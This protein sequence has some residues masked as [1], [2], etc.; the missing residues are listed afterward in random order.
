[1]HSLIFGTFLGSSLDTERPPKD[2]LIYGA[3]VALESFYRG[4]LRYGTFDEYHFFF[5]ASVVAQ[6]FK[7]NLQALGIYT[8]K[9]KLI[10][11]DRL[12]A[13][14]QKNKYTIFLADQISGLSEV[15]YLR[16]RY[17]K[18]LFP[19]CALTHSISYPEMLKEQFFENLLSDVYPF[20]S[21]ICTSTA[22]LKAIKKLYWLASN[23]AK[24]RLGLDLEYK[25][26]FKHLP[27]GINIGDYKKT[28]KS[29][30]RRLLGLPQDK[31]IILYFGRFS[32]YDKADLEP[33]LIA[34]KKVLEKRSDIL[35]LLAGRDAQGRYGIKVKK[36]AQDMGLSSKVRFFLNPS[37][38]NKYLL[39]SASDIFTSP[40]DSIQESFGLT[41][42]EAMA[43]GLATVVSDWDGYK[44]IVI[45]KK[46][47]FLVPTFWAD[48]DNE[49]AY[50][51]R[52][53]T[54]AQSHFYLSQSVCIDIEKMA[55][56]LLK[57]IKDKNLCLSLG[58]NSRQRVLENYD[59]KV[60]V[61]KYEKL[62]KEMSNLSKN[63]TL[64]SRKNKFL[65]PDYIKC[66]GHYP[67]RMLDERAKITI[68]KNGREFLR[69]K[70]TL[71]CDE[72]LYRVLSMS[73]IYAILSLLLERTVS[74]MG[75][76]I[77][78]IKQNFKNIS[79][80]NIRYHIMWLSK[81]DM[82]KV[83]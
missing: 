67:T 58:S 1:M 71:F 37:L 35:L 64:D 28:D 25:G 6:Q 74:S 17:A 69:T 13:S 43:F 79:A 3:Q 48:C 36:I 47:G 20:D 41:I 9:I 56:Y 50:L 66:F 76:I 80:D 45:H 55:E 77:G 33:L 23:Y 42:L 65:L 44:D 40:S 21:A 10:N 11:F 32:I 18:T 57:L 59:W 2:F 38:N 19:V 27:L 15:T 5:N 73:V 70:K 22:Q 49:M 82:V 72:E 31:T 8:D 4:L 54:F 14:L 62:W 26:R 12:P 29:H 60:L 63:F 75:R 24:K 39:Y 51:S 34:F 16:N 53:K 61:P 46:T 68:S 78:Q 83:K 7:K 30:A 81:K 52:I